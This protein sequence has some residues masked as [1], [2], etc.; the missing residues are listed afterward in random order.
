MFRYFLLSLLFGGCSFY[1]RSIHDDDRKIIQ[2][3]LTCDGIE[4]RGF[5]DA[6]VEDEEEDDDGF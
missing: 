2:G 4:C 1:F 3:G 5:A 6:L